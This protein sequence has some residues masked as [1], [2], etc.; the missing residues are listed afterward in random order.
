[1]AGAFPFAGES[2]SI[3]ATVPP[4]VAA[5]HPSRDAGGRRGSRFVERAESEERDAERL[6]G[7]HDRVAGVGERTRTAA[8]ARG[9]TSAPGWKSSLSPPS[10]GCITIVVAV[11][12]IVTCASDVIA[13]SAGSTAE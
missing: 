9:S 2:A 6:L 5:D 3:A 12:E 11:S 7:D 4:G 8:Y 1:M 10:F 13:A